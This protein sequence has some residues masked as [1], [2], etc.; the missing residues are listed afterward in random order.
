MR[1]LRRL[2]L[3][4]SL[5]GLGSTSELQEALCLACRDAWLEPSSEGRSGMHS[6]VAEQ[7]Q[8]FN[9]VNVS[10]AD[11]HREPAVAD[12]PESAECTHANWHAA[13]EAARSDARKDRVSNH[14]TFCSGHAAT[15]VEGMSPAAWIRLM[16]AQRPRSRHGVQS[17]KRT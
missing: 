15:S 2:C 9:L 5:L 8:C 11:C 17:A 13:R 12:I 4:G 14:F 10:C 1:R 7:A 16:Y 6:N 3:L